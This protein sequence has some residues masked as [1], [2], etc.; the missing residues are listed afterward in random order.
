MNPG[1]SF[2][3]TSVLLGTGLAMDAFSVS[4]A[5]GLNEP[6]MKKRRMIC[7]ALVFAGFQLIM[8]LIGWFCV[9]AAAHIFASFEKYVPLIAFSLLLFIGAKMLYE[10]VKSKNADEP[11]PAVG[12]GALL[13][14]GVATSIDA[15]SVGFAIEQY[16]F[17]QALAS[18]LI[19]GAVTFV[20]CFAGVEAGKR[21]GTKL[22]GKAGTAGGVILIL[23]GLEILLKSIIG[24]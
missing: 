18:C 1:F 7:I 24:R 13:L 15:L 5:N 4:L 9:S 19:I 2:I 23:I 12:A 11:K 22:A 8:P 14:Q 17:A 10:G 20:I 21:A 3:I 16:V 6:Q